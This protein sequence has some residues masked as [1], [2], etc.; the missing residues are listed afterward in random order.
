MLIFLLSLPVQ[1]TKIGRKTTGSET[2]CALK[3]RSFKTDGRKVGKA[4]ILWK[5][6]KCP[7]S[8]LRFR[9]K[10]QTVYFGLYSFHVKGNYI[11]TPG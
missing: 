9:Y 1:L 4:K 5:K 8:Q 10:V 2:P 11:L 6:G 7:S 3:F